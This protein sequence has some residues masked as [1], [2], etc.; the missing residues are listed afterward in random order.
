M[1]KSHAI[2]VVLL[3]DTHLAAAFTVKRELA[4][5]YRALSRPN[6]YTIY[7][8]ENP[9]S[10]CGGRLGSVDLGMKPVHVT[11][12]EIRQSLPRDER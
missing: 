6:W 12:E 5:W 3:Y 8:C 11:W 4:K 2:W 9:V 1:A 10:S 7:R